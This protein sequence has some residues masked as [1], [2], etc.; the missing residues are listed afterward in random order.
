MYVPPVSW[1]EPRAHVLNVRCMGANSTGYERYE[2]LAVEL[3]RALRGRRSC[4]ELSRR[5]GYHSNIVH[6]WET[7]HCWPTAAR[8]IAVHH[9]LR[10]GAG[11]WLEKFSYGAPQWLGARDPAAPEVI[12]E[13]LQRL[14]GQTPVVRIAELAS[15]NRYTVARW[16]DGSAQP[17]LPEFLQLVDVAGRR[18]LELL[19]CFVDPAQ[20]PSVRAQWQRLQLAR[21]A[22]YDK[23]WSHAVLRALELDG[24]ARRMPGQAHWIAARLAID[25]REVHDALVLLEATGQVQ[26]TRRGFVPQPAQVVDTRQDPR[27]ALELKASW[28]ATALERMRRGD[29]GSY[30]YSLFAISRADM[31]RLRNLHLEYVRAMQS[32]IARSQ[33]NECVGLYCAQLLALEP[34]ATRS[35]DSGTG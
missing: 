18:L 32:V 12:A 8:F 13:F 5:A 19:A 27:R 16:F 7:R 25:V 22:A 3:V 34:E 20:L 6:R 24:S 23:P 2:T 17:K 26:R 14:R 11:S 21:E 10:P 9:K 4:A 1:D 35:T 15:R 30:G 29:G 28:T 31:Q 33:P